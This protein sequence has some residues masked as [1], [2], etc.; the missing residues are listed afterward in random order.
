MDRIR[1]LLAWLLLLALPL[2]GAAAVAMQ[3][4]GTAGAAQVASVQP[5]AS[6]HP[7]PGHHHHP[8]E[9]AAGLVAASDFPDAQADQADAGH[10]CAWCAFCGHALALHSASP[11]AGPA[12]PPGAAPDAP[13]DALVSLSLPVPDKP[14][15]R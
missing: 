8:A 2:Q 9:A 3:A 4:C 13:R 14:P 1:I 7:D 5:H 11:R 10:A 6:H 15:R 12:A